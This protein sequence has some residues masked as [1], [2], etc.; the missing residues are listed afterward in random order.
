[1]VPAAALALFTAAELE[2]MCCGEVKRNMWNPNLALTLAPALALSPALTPALALTLTL[3][4]TQY[5]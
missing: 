5:P 1:M 4:L 2:R 3:T